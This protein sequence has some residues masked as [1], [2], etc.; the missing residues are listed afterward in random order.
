[1]GTTTLTSAAPV[2]PTVAHLRKIRI[3]ADRTPIDEREFQCLLGAVYVPGRVLEDGTWTISDEVARRWS[4]HHASSFD[5]MWE[6]AWECVA[7][8]SGQR[9][10]AEPRVSCEWMAGDFG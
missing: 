1:M 2:T 6:L 4:R 8:L 7:I 9:E 3:L 10:V 5:C